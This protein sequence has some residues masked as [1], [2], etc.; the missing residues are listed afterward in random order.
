MIEGIQVVRNI[1]PEEWNQV[2]LECLEAQGFYPIKD[3]S[4]SIPEEQKQAWGLAQYSCLA[5][6][7]VDS[8][9]AGPYGE[10]EHRRFYE[11]WGETTIPCLVENGYPVNELPSFEVFQANV[12]TPNEFYP[13]ALD[14]L[15]E[16]G[17]EAEATCR[18]IPSSDYIRGFSDTP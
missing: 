2:N 11:Y 15:S 6:F 10:S 12:G 9:Y 1:K 13:L 4:Y 17:L 3:G 7:P 16:R 14:S 8:A 5:Q 18:T